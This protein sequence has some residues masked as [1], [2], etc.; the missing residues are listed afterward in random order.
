M[1]F[2]GIARRHYFEGWY[3]KN[4]ALDGAAYSFIPGASFDDRGDGHAFVQVIRGSDGASSYERYGLADFSA[5]RDALAVKVGPNVFT[6]DG[7]SVELPEAFGGISGDLAYG[8]NRRLRRSLLRPGIMGWYR[9]AAFMECYHEVGS[10]AHTV[11]GTLVVGGSPVEFG[12]A[13]GATCGRGYLEKDWGTSM[14][15]AWVWVHGNGFAEPTD[16]VMVSIARIPWLGGSF[17]GFLGFVSAGDRL[18]QFGT[19]S[20]ARITRLDA[21]GR[22]VSISVRAGS[23][24]IDIDGTRTHA[25]TLAAPVGGAMDRRIAE[26]LDATLRLTI[27]EAGRRPAT[28]SGGS[29]GI[30]IV[31][32]VQ[33]LRPT[34]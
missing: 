32:D 21:E 10:V 19:Y 31:G 6:R 4:V 14:P 3:F 11:R 13:G 16:S 15:A 7:I 33:T 9:Y 26:S 29:A 20:G 34:A 27:T 22:R 24:K 2:Q 17:T 12:A 25:G 23:V 18:M 1:A 28:M 30:E 5:A 8:A